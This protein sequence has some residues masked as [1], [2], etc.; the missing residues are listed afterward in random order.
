MAQG[1]QSVTGAMPG[2]PRVSDHPLAS[3]A[4]HGPSRDPPAPLPKVL[5]ALAEPSATP[6]LTLQHSDYFLA[7]LLENL[8]WLCS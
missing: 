8:Q 3:Q 4:A 2:H 6:A 1:L 5:A 7:R